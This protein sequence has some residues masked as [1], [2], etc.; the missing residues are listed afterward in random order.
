MRKYSKAMF[1]R[2]RKLTQDI[3]QDSICEV[4]GLSKDD[5]SE[6]DAAMG[7]IRTKYMPIDMYDEDEI[8]LMRETKESVDILY[9]KKV[10]ALPTV[11]LEEI[12]TVH[13]HGEIKRAPRTVEAIL[14]E[15]VR[16]SVFG[17]TNES[18]KNNKNGDV[19]EPKRQ[20]KLNSKKAIGKRGKTPEN[21]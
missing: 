20:S 15:L 9:L 5:H 19:D 2:V 10:I 3:F 13:E 4:L 8:E 1:N 12:M 18:D 16:R 11:K 7:F 6:I 21:R 17:D 14:S